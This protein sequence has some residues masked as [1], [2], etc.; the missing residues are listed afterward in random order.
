[1]NQPVWWC[2]VR[3]VRAQ[4]LT[5]KVYQLSNV[6]DLATYNDSKFI[7][8]DVLVHQYYNL[9]G[10]LS[11]PTRVPPIIGLKYLLEYHTLVLFMKTKYSI[12]IW[13]RKPARIWTQNFG[14][15]SSLAHHWVPL[16]WLSYIFSDFFVFHCFWAACFYFSHFSGLIKLKILQKLV[17]FL[18]YHHTLDT[19]AFI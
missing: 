15:K 19:S 7:H 3:R 11:P 14:T 2:P 18:F 8:I 4:V 9:S 16:H 1:M 17:I 13:N 10:Y 5:I 6:I 12:W